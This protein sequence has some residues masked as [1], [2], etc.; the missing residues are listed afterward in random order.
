MQIG[1]SNITTMSMA[2]YFIDS[3]LYTQKDYIILS[4]YIP[5]VDYRHYVFV[6]L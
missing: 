6:L 1:K 3:I 4:I 2:G 5:K